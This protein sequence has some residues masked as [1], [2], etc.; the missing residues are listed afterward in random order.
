M[1]EEKRNSQGVWGQNCAQTTHIKTNVGQTPYSTT[2]KKQQ[3][4]QRSNKTG[5]QLCKN[6]PTFGKKLVIILTYQL[7]KKEYSLQ[8]T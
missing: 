5:N 4:Q 7:M 6:M 3:L 1:D 2:I 8:P